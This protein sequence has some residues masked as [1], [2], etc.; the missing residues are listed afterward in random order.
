MDPLTITSAVISISARCIQSARALY[1]LRGKYKDASMTITA[2]YSESTV[3]STSLAHIQGL[4]SKNPDALRSTLQERP[5]LEATFDQ[6]LTGCV[7]VYSVLDDEVRRLYT[8]IGKEGVAGMVGRV[9]FLWKEEAM[10]DV[11]VQI[12]G[13][14]T[15]LGL[16]IQALQMS[17]INDI[18]TLL[19]NNTSILQGVAQRTSKFR[20]ANLRVKAPGSI[21]EFAKDDDVASIYSADSRATST[22]FIFDDLVVNSQAYRRAL[23]QSRSSVNLAPLQEQ[24]EISSDADTVV[25]GSPAAE[26]QKW[27]IPL[28]IRLK[29]SPGE[30]NT[31]CKRLDDAVKAYS[32]SD[33]PARFEELTKE[34]LILKEKYIKLKRYYFEMQEKKDNEVRDREMLAAEYTRVVAEKAEVE[35]TKSFLEEQNVKLTEFFREN[36]NKKKLLIDS[37]D[38][39]LQIKDDKIVQLEESYAKEKETSTKQR[40]TISSKSSQITALEDAFNVLEVEHKECAAKIKECEEQ[41]DVVVAER[42]AKEDEIQ[43]Y[44][45]FDSIIE[46]LRLLS[47][48]PPTSP[49]GSSINRPASAEYRPSS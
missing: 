32:D 20:Q 30:I 22:N 14:Q 28:G 15:A 36:E 19:Q 13:Q 24:S 12:R 49:G 18:R 27:K 33:A 29:L 39:V 1:D 44:K 5:E 37:H 9:K 17:S 34:H 4:I 42:N 8:G 45:G 41:I 25:E 47:P 10:R 46:Q 2:I 16:L 38:K 3:I 6:A 40:E 7:L 35:Q 11:L 21:F 26:A 43:R 48:A 31:L 23:S